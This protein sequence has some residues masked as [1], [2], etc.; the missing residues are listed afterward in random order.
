LGLHNG[1]P[2]TII[3]T[4]TVQQLQDAAGWAAT[5]G[6][7]RLPV[8]DLIKMASHSIHCLAVFD[9]ADNRPLHFGRTKRIATGDQRLVLHATDRGCTYPGCTIPGYLTEV[10]HCTQWAQGGRTDIDD[11]T[12]ACKPHHR[13]ITTHNWTTHKNA[14]G[15]T[16]WKPPPQSPHKGGVNNFHH[17][18]RLLDGD[19]DTSADPPDT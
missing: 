5:A 9:D 17:P 13:L 19:R 18:E 4:V 2:V 8:T 15:H 12:F 7:T 11:L 16:E 3:A 10:H 1:L 14:L 6:G